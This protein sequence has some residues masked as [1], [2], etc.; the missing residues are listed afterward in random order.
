MNNIFEKIKSATS[1]PQLPQIMLQLIQACGKEK[2][3]IDEITQIIGKDAALTAKLLAII[4]SPYVNLAKQVTTIKSAVV[5]LGL[6]TVRNIAISSSAMQFFQFS[7]SIE[8]FDINRFWYHSYK[9]AVLARRIAIEENQVNPDQYFLAGLLHDIGTLVLMAT[10]P[11][12]YKVIEAR[13]NQGQNEFKAQAD[14]LETDGAQVS[15]WLFNQWHLSPMTSDAVRCLNQPLT[16]ITKEKSHV[17]ILFLANLMAEPERTE[18]IQDAHLLTGL[19]PDVLNDMAVQAENEVHQMAKSLNLILNKRPKTALAPEQENSLLAEGLKDASV[20]FGTLDN[21]LRAKD[22]AT[23][24]ETVQRGLEIIFQVPRVFFFLQNPEKN[25]LMGTCT[26]ADRHYN[27]VTSIALAGN[28]NPGLIVSAAKTGKIVTSADQKKPAQSDIQIIRLLETPAFYAIPIPGH[29]G[30]AGVMVLGVDKD[31]ARTLDKNRTLLQLFSQQTGICLKNLNFH[32]AYARDIND[33]KMEAY[34]I[35]TDKVVHEINNPV[36]IIKNYLETLKLKLPEK[37][38]AQEDLSII[39][40]EMSRIS[41]LLEGLTSF[42]RPGVGM[43]P[44]SIDLNQLCGRVLSVLKKSLLLPR[45]IHLQTD[46]DDAIPKA[47][48]DINGLKQVIINLVKNAAEALEKG[49]EIRFTTKLVPGS[50]KVLIDEK[51]KLPGFVAITIQDNGPGI[52]SHI[53]ERLFEPYNSTKSTSA[54]SGLGLAIVYSIVNKMQGRITCNS[55]NGKGTC[56]TIILPLEPDTGSGW[57]DEHD[58]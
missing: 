49:N 28:N 13:L 52:P 19:S 36:A 35:L 47:T 26:K 41:S 25:L 10:F 46:L 50:T 22:V 1:L 34:A 15:A 23:V 17:K 40:E 24:L 33:K 30:C 8:N 54:G 56:F 21:L 45:Q 11:E 2:S 31:L 39:N 7:D 43:G 18:V 32:K 5:Y 12:E 55:D 51:R 3:H 38:P 6:D 53:S 16:H 58:R 42:S 4:A 44:E 27:V 57:P 48:M 9:C 29:N 20:F 37:H 14:I